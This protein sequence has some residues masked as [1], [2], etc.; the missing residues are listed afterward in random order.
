MHKF[1][2]PAAAAALAAHNQGKFWEYHHK[3]FENMSALTDAKFMDMAKEL[4]LDLQ[5]FVNDMNSPATQNLINRD[6]TEGKRARVT[7]TPS[8]FVNGKLLKERSIEGFQVII[9]AELK[10]KK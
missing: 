6:L 2:R 7:G 3:I 8:I 9:D 1:A 4:K 10:K 5:K